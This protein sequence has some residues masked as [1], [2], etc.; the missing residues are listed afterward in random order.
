MKTR[1]LCVAALLACAAG[2]GDGLNRGGELSGKVLLGDKPIGG[3]RVEI[4]S[5]DDR[6]SGSCEVRPDG[7]YTLKEP[8][9]GKCKLVVTTSHLKGI[10]LPPRNDKGK[11]S[12]SS[13]G[14]MFPEDVGLV[15][16]PI[17]ERYERREQTDLSVI[18]A[19]GK[20]PHDVVL[21]AK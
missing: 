10:P 18:V 9:L 13:G 14:M 11:V 7:G 6:H 15:Y 20:Q 16:V 17:P 1:V 8:P 21:S 2:C 12:G 4:F 19:R 3:G 5:A